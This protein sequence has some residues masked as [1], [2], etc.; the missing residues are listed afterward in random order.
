MLPHEII[1]E[2]KFYFGLEDKD[3]NQIY[4]YDK[5]IQ[6]NAFKIIKKI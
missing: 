6:S 4:L 1:D 3:N 5:Y 2:N